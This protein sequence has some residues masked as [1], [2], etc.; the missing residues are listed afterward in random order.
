MIETARRHPGSFWTAVL[1]R[2]ATAGGLPYPSCSPV[3]AACNLA[4]PRHRES[5][6]HAAP[7]F[8]THFPLAARDARRRAMGGAMAAARV[9]PTR[10]LRATAGPRRLPHA[11]PRGFPGFQVS[12]SPGRRPHPPSPPPGRARRGRRRGEELKSWNPG[13]WGVRERAAGSQVSRFPAR[14]LPLAPGDRRCG[15]APR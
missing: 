12:S 11:A 14:R 4:R 3:A 10:A 5:P 6:R 1:D 8:R 7:A 2:I 15:V 13:T 9:R